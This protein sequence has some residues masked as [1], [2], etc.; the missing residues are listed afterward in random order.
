MDIVLI[1]IL[2]LEEYG[3]YIEYIQDHKNIVEYALSGFPINRNQDTTKD[4]TYKKEV[5]SEINDIK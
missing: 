2:V 3:T 5:M 1:W 4:P